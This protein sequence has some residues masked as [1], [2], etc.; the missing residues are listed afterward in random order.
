MSRVRIAIGISVC[1]S[2]G[3]LSYPVKNEEIN[4]KGGSRSVGAYCFLPAPRQLRAEHEIQSPASINTL[5]EN[6]LRPLPDILVRAVRLNASREML[7]W[8]FAGK[9]YKR[10]AYGIISTRSSKWSCDR[11]ER[12]ESV[13][14]ILTPP[15]RPKQRTNKMQRE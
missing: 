7:S 8:V 12:C 6:L 1:I 4:A 11:T 10:R 14:Q 2:N 15:P 5:S 13:T 3:F 9:E